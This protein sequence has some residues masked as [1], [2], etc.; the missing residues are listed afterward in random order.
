M[1]DLVRVFGIGVENVGMTECRGIDV[2]NRTCH[3]VEE[4]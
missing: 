1:K 2:P 3:R 4:S